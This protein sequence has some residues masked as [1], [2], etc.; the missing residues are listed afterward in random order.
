MMRVQ[1]FYCGQRI[2]TLD[3]IP[4]ATVV[5]VNRGEKVM[6]E[7][8]VHTLE[9]APAASQPLLEA[10]KREWGFLPTLHAILAE[11]PAALE[12]YRQLF[13]LVGKSSFSPAEQQ[14]VFL[15]VS[16][17]HECSYCTA[18][19]T[20]LARSVK[21]SEPVIAALRDA[22]P[23]DD[24]RLQAL[25]AFTERVL[26]TRGHAGD[27]AVAMFLAA[28]FTHAQVLEVVLV[29]ATKTISNYANHL[30]HTPAEAFMSDPA[31]GWVPPRLRTREE[32]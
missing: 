12:G 25:R 2:Y 5:G 4:Q 7:F 20:Y 9:S 26:Q 17:F 19:H 15:A 31:F 28:G 6:Q 13:A 10:T 27:D 16:V 8:K 24:P 14:V 30:T 32:A 11:S 23:I 21:L 22:K 18:G 3:P 29:I 1:A